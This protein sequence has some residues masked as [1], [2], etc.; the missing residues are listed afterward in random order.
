M[1]ASALETFLAKHIGLDVQSVG[2]SLIEQAQAKRMLATGAASVR[3][4]VRLL[5]HSSEEKKALIDNIVVLETWFFRNDAAFDF[6]AKCARENW[7][8]QPPQRVFRV[9]SMPCATGEEAYSIAMTLLENGIAPERFVVDAVDICERALALAKKG[10]Y[11]QSSFRG[12]V[13]LKFRQRYFQQLNSDTGLEHYQ[14]DSAIQKQ[15]RFVQGNL[16]EPSFSLLQPGYDVVFCRNLLIY[17]TTAAR[18]Q[19]VNTLARF[20]ADDGILFLGHAER[21]MVCEQGLVQIPQAGAFACRK[22]RPQDSANHDKKTRPRKPVKLSLPPMP[23]IE[24]A[25]EATPPSPKPASL[26]LSSHAS[27]TFSVTEA[28]APQNQDNVHHLLEEAQRL[29]DQGLLPEALAAC[30]KCLRR[31]PDDIP[32]NFLLGVVYQALDKDTQAE[33]YFNKT[34][35]LDP[36]HLDALN[37]LAFLV[38][39]R[40][41][42]E[43]ALRLRQR[44]QRL[45]ER[46][47]MRV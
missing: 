15:V 14:I 1:P 34:L 44:L 19:A 32:A 30:E 6:L 26:S 35:Y 4:Y 5:E 13:A 11:G 7:L 42:R 40:G 22:P 20:L 41:Q 8:K 17:F 25:P 45:R 16:L 18:K 33:N 43:H 2:T 29:A 21:S 36:T 28:Q 23:T 37:H 24:T 3:D 38:E 9:L 27:N 12:Q 47:N 31:K 46:G 39:K 10:V